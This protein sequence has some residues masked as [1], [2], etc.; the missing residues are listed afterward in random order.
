VA[1]K[2]SGTI[3]EKV[4]GGLDCANLTKQRQFM[5]EFDIISKQL[6]KDY[7]EDFIRFTLNRKRF[8]VLEIIDTELPTVESRHADVLARVRVGGREVLVHNE[9]QAG[10]STTIPMPL[11]MSGYIG[12]SVESLGIP[13]CSSVIYLRPDAGRNDPG[14]YRYRIGE[15]GF[16][17][18][19]RVIRLIEMSGQDVI[20]QK[21]W[22]LLP[23]APLMRPPEG[24]LPENWLRQCVQTTDD[25]S[26]DAIGQA[27]FL[28]D[29]AVLSGLV[30][31][32]ETVFDIISEEIMYESSVTQRLTE[33][34]RERL[35]AQITQQVTDQVTQQVTDQVTQQVTAQVT[36]QAHR[37]SQVLLIHHF[38]S[39]KFGTIHAD[40]MKPSLE[41]IEDTDVLRRLFDV[42]IDA[43]SFDEF[44]KTVEVQIGSE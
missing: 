34:L 16:S 26:L 9:F 21:L 35:T 17:V 5:A 33:R 18:S 32:A 36:R 22:G 23:F 6:F 44:Q 13:V 11:R 12:R 7:P 8:Q 37:E 24:V 42:A 29:L 4:G 2:I 25:L 30:Y 14:R 3:A 31:N 40:Q 27:N 1:G 43:Q 10:D 15:F 28:T 20:D 39:K 19:Y 41:A 38:V